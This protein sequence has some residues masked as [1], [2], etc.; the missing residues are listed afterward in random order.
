MADKAGIEPAA[1]QVLIDV[2]EKLT[3]HLKNAEEHLIAALE[4]FGM[5]YKPERHKDYVKRLER[6]Q[7][8]VTGLV[9]EELIRI[10]G[11]V[12]KIAVSAG[13]KRKK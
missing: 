12:K 3:F 8:L 4:L 5:E 13:I 11:P 6:A 2:D 7:L 1:K 10:R 9:R